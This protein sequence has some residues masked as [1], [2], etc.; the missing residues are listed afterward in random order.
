MQW[1]GSPG[2]GFTAHSKPWLPLAPDFRQVNTAS[3][4]A[5]PGSILAFYRRMIWLRKSCPAL[6][7]GTYRCRE[8]VPGDCL[9]YL[10]ET[11]GQKLLVAL[12]FSASSRSISLA[13][14][15]DASLI[16]STDEGRELGATRGV[17]VLGPNEGCIVDLTR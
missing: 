16:I 1:D 11:S 12:N 8:D 13:D 14:G 15:P 4:S 6:L 5:D 9:V 10:R 2:A 7:Q 3:E 17:L